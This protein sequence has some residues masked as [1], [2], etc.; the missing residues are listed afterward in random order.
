MWIREEGGVELFMCEFDSHEFGIVG[1]G[2]KF[3]LLIEEHL[4]G[5]ECF[6]LKQHYMWT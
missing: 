4:P 1:V 5:L 6:G 3:G 2:G